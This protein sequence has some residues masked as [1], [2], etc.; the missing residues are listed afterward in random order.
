MEKESI[1]SIK[2]ILEKKSVKNGA[3]MY[4][5]QIF[6]TIVPL[7]TLPYITRI[8]GASQYGMFSIAINIITY[9]QVIVEYGFG[10]SATRKLPVYFK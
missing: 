2:S 10:M 8:L 7:L 6:N 1:L 4:L 9:F 5:L 3:W